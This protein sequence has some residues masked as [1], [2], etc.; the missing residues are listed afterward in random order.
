MQR[1]EMIRSVEI[2]IIV[3]QSALFFYSYFF[4]HFQPLYIIPTHITPI[5]VAQ[6]TFLEHKLM[7]F[8]LIFSRED[9][10]KKSGASG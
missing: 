3:Q 9:E 2:A 7:Q 5:I 8:I 6:R 4:P 10:A 1:R